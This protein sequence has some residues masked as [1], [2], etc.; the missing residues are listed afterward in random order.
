MKFIHTAD[1]H[2]DSPF[3]NL[4]GGQMPESLW[5]L[6][7]HSPYESFRRIVQ[8]AINQ[9]VDFM[10][11]VGDFFDRENQ[12]VRA[13]SFLKQQLEL[14]NQ[15]HIPVLMSFG[16]HDYYQG[17]ISALHYPQNTYIFPHAVTT[18]RL[19][20]KDGT[21]VAVSG[22]SY[23]HR[24]QDQRMIND[25]PVKGSADYQ[26]GMIHGQVSTGDAHYTPFSL[27]ELK[28]KH[29]DYWA[30]G[31]VHK[32]QVLSAHPPV[33]YCGNIQ[34]RTPNETGDKGYLLVDSKRTLKPVF[35]PTSVLNWQSLE[36]QVPQVKSTTEL[37]S[38]I[39][40]FLHAQA[41]QKLTLLDLHLIIPTNVQL[42][43]DLITLIQN[44]NVLDQVQSELVDTYQKLKVWVTE[45]H[46]SFQKKHS[47]V[48]LD[49]PYWQAGAKN[50]FTAG[51]VTTVAKKLFRENFINHYFNCPQGRQRLRQA[52]QAFLEENGGHSDE[53]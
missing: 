9:Q 35:H 25:F 45:L 4:A 14:L 19:T 53:N 48:N 6:I 28:A 5:N 11:I 43:N 21:T 47:A 44:G 37:V 15:L 34:G 40:Q 52:T 39:Q 18:H 12:S 31:H 13:Q 38:R 3:H 27:A 24:W 20:L 46:L 1:L 17:K 10:L 2:L 8:A 41:F 16:N 30:S 49:T 22:F 33:Y 50:V 23:G 29:Y 42:S 32:R 51:N 7:Y 26:L 36:F